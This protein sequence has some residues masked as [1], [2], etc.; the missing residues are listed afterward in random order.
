MNS[1]F[2]LVLATGCFA[3]PLQQGEDE[4]AELK[5]LLKR[6]VRQ[7]L[8]RQLTGHIG[9]EIEDMARELK[10]APAKV[11]RLRLAAKGVAGKFIDRYEA[12]VIG[13]IRQHVNETDAS[14][15]GIHIESLRDAGEKITPVPATRRARNRVALVIREDRI[16]PE[17]SSDRSTY[18][19]SVRGG[20]REFRRQ[21][22]WTKV[23]STVLSAQ[24]RK[25]YQQAVT[26]RRRRR[27][28]QLVNQ[29]LMID[30][31]L[32][33]EAGE[34]LHK[35]LDQRLRKLDDSIISAGSPAAIG[36]ITRSLKPDGLDAI[37]T[38][39]QQAVFASMV[40]R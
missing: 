19:T 35:W 22:L 14:V 28:V 24:E 29:S 23:V 36:R 40:T 9:I 11:K 30:L 21:G 16:R 37:L 20:L 2:C 26:E 8:Q 39:D 31:R 5:T 6:A 15:N 18:G 10:L 33:D 27:Y 25:T 17:V 32:S 12:R 7:D 13:F 1:L 4:Q 38:K 34:K 3:A